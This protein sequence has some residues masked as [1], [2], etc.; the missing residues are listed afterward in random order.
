VAS[1]FVVGVRESKGLDL[2][3]IGDERVAD[4]AAELV[5]DRVVGEVEALQE[6]LADGVQELPDGVVCGCLCGE[7]VEG[8]GGGAG[9]N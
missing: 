5:E 4:Q 2:L 9:T 8:Y 3:E 7:A 6:V 1:Q